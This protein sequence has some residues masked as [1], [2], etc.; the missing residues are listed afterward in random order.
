M[1]GKEDISA[2]R[3][4]GQEP[5]PSGPVSDEAARFMARGM[6]VAVEILRILAEE[7]AMAALPGPEALRAAASSIEKAAKENAE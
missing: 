2:E 6:M 5:D 3:M 1:T 7:R 4:G